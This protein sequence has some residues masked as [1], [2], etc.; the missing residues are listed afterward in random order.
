MKTKWQNTSECSTGIGHSGA[1]DAINVLHPCWKIILCIWWSRKTPGG[2]MWGEIGFYSSIQHS[3]WK[4]MLVN[5][6]GEL[7]QFVKS[8]IIFMFLPLLWK[9]LRNIWNVVYS[10][11][12]KSHKIHFQEYTVIL[13][14]SHC[15]LLK[16]S[17]PVSLIMNPLTLY[18]LSSVCV[19]SILFSKHFL[20]SWQREFGKQSRAFLVGDHFLYFCDLNVCHSGG[21]TSKRD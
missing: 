7:L 4:A 21:D 12:F 14:M 3:E 6:D 1:T 13:K 17:F 10:V 11:T 5:I 15:F 20:P 2:G 16:L 19:F 9:N 8:H 18:T